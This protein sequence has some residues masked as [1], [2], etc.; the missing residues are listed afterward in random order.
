MKCDVDSFSILDRL[1]TRNGYQT[2]RNYSNRRRNSNSIG[3][4]NR[5]DNRTV[6]KLDFISDSISNRIRNHIKQNNL[7]TY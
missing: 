2:P 5:D 6:L 3:N 4:R 7:P 1:M